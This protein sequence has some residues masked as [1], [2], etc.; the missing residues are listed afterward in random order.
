MTILAIGPTG[1]GGGDYWDDGPAPSWISHRGDTNGSIIGGLRIRHGNWIDAIQWGWRTNIPG[2]PI[3]WF[4]RHG[5]DGGNE[6]EILFHDDEWIIKMWGR[7]GNYIDHIY[8]VT[9][10]N[11]QFDY[12][13]DGGSTDWAFWTD[14]TPDSAIIGLFGRAHTYLDALGYYRFSP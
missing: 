4:G 7:F 13:G 6:D 11:R 14:G 2:T 8:I 9:N 5:G 3:Q 12:G 10:Q 1:G